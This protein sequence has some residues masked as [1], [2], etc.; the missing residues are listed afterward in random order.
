MYFAL[1]KW[2]W[3]VGGVKSILLFQ[4]YMSVKPCQPS[5][6][7]P[8]WTSEQRHHGEADSFTEQSFNLS[9]EQVCRTRKHPNTSHHTTSCSSELV[10]HPFSALHVCLGRLQEANMGG[11]PRLQLWKNTYWKSQE[12][13]IHSDLT[14]LRFLSEKGNCGVIPHQ[15]GSYFRPCFSSFVPC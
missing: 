5:F 9:V 15:P 11:E 3:H 8:C 13:G 12:D 4:K 1:F 14:H 7:T 2:G 6:L 10:H